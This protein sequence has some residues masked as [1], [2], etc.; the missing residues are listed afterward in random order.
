MSKSLIEQAKEL[1]K[2]LEQ[3]PSALNKFE[4]DAYFQELKKAKIYD[5]KTKKKIAELPTNSTSKEA[6]PIV[7]EGEK[8]ITNRKHLREKY[9]PDIMPEKQNVP[10]GEEVTKAEKSKKPFHGYNPKKHAKTGGLNDKYR[11]KL[12]RETGSKLKRPSKDKKNSRHKSFCARMKGVKGPTS[13][14]GKLTPKGAA[15]KRWNCSKNEHT[16]EKMCKKDR[17][18]KGYEPTPGKKPYEK[19]SCRPIKKSHEY[20]YN[21]VKSVL[22][23]NYN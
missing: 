2:Q 11:K 4:K 23:K 15:L 8:G 9:S 5:F 3:D 22:E 6:Q 7:R 19:G 16:D 14:E 17:C 12:N 1:L 13:K 18:W 10:G 20:Y 21:L